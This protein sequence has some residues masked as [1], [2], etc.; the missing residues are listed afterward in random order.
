[1]SVT[2]GPRPAMLKSSSVK[3]TINVAIDCFNARICKISIATSHVI[4]KTKQKSWF[5]V[6]TPIRFTKSVTTVRI[7]RQWFTRKTLLNKQDLNFMGHAKLLDDPIS[8]NASHQKS[9][10]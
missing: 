8:L 3:A 5:W 1:M 10:S 4:L 2:L 6:Y 7:S 9:I